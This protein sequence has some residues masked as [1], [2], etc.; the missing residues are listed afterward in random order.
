MEIASLILLI[1]FAFISFVH[2]L[3]ELLV[4]FG[5]D[6]FVLAR[7]I[8]KPLLIPLLLAFFV[9][10][11]SNFS[12]YE[13]WFVIALVFGFLGDVFL[14]IP[15]PEK[16][17]LGLKLG[18][19]AFLLGHISYILAF[20]IN[21][22][23]FIF[24]QWWGMFLALP[25][26][27]AASIAHPY[28]T[29]NTGKMTKA[30]TA[31]IFVICLMCVSS[32]FLFLPE[33]WS[34]YQLGAIIVYLGVWLFAVSDLFNGIGRFVKEFRYERLVTMFAYISG[35]L[36]IVLGFIIWLKGSL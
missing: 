34:N 35:Q 21:A 36:L 1:I 6:K 10:S 20:I 9:S 11:L 16:K 33:G 24:W 7:F 32:T 25:F 13:V 4:D 23:G 15:D 27:G 3:G 29:K 8:T 26:V 22:R 18:L 28:I 2:L 19:S 5:K 30:V 14:M 31:Y 17:R 12:V